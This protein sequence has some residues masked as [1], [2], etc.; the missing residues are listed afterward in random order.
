M[1]RE[2]AMQ[3]KN[4]LEWMKHPE[5]WSNWPIQTLRNRSRE[6]AQANIGQW[7]LGVLLDQENPHKFVVYL[8]PRGLLDWST[9]D[10]LTSCQKE[11]YRTYEEIIAAGW[12]VD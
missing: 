6:P 1:T 11:Q 4:H 3:E 2:Q 5:W 9:L 7:V 8:T 12:E 10:K